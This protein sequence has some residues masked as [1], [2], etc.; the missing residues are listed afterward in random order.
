M[1]DL[2]GAPHRDT[3]RGRDA[4]HW[5]WLLLGVTLAGRLLLG[6]TVGLGIDEAYTVS[7]A[8]TFELSTFDHP[9]LAWWL[10]GLG[11]MFGA[12]SAVLVRLPFIVLFALTTWLAFIAGRDLFGARAGLFAAITLNLAPVIG[13]TTGTFVVPD[14]P[15]MA[16]M[17]GAQSLL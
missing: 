15:L 10:A 11:R 5:L 16:A 14:G 8:K 17:L 2:T 3:W 4:I 9:P 7:T 12:D 6:A 13:W 1:A